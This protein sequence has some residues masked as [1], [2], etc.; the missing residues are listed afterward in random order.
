[1]LERCRNCHACRR[2]CPTGAISD[3][4]FLLH[5]ER[6][7]PFHNERPGRIPFPQWLAPSWHNSLQGCLLC[8]RICPEDRQLLQWFG[9]Q[10]EFDEAETDLLSRGTTAAELAAST[11][12]KLE[13]LD[14]LNSLDALPRNLGV[15]LNLNERA[16]A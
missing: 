11:R 9:E 8:Q 5:A 1:M 3:T 2:H 15:L 10:A 4:R 12:E 6:C 7:I 14:L 13:Y 16:M